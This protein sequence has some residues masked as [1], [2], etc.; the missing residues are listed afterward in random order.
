MGT[1]LPAKGEQPPPQFS[2]NV[3]CGQTAGWIKMPPATEISLG[4]GDIVLDGDPAPLERKGAQRPHFSAHVYCGQTAGWIKMPLG[5]EVGLGPSHIV[6]DGNPASPPPKK[7]EKGH[8][9]PQLSGSSLL[10][11]ND[12]TSQPGLS[13][14][15]LVLGRDPAPHMR[16]LRKWGL[17]CPFP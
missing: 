9:S 14:C 2:A 5:T 16:K 11:P 3:S 13:S 17:L 7:K 1:Q 4:P 12:R 15:M 6:L 8:S 10:W